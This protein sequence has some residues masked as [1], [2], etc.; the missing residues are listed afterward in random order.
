MTLNVGNRDHKIQLQM[1][2]METIKKSKT[3]FCPGVIKFLLPP[4][5]VCNND[6]VG[7][8][9]G[10][11]WIQLEIGNSAEQIQTV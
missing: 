8:D 5:P 4:G 9:I 1:C 11:F 10:L 2:L 3:F 7:K 6:V